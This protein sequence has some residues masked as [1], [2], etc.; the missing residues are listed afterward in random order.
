MPFTMGPWIL[1]GISG[2]MITTQS[3]YM[4]DGFIAD[5][6]TFE[7]AEFIVRACNA[8]HDL[9]EALELSLCL[10]LPNKR[11]EQTAKLEAAGWSS[12]D[13]FEYPATQ[14]VKDKMQAALK[15]ARGE[16]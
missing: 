2:R 5:V 12:E 9:I 1:G 15:K 7:N 8:H 14:F 10:D 3:G 6:D 4:G 13:R 16:S 11:G